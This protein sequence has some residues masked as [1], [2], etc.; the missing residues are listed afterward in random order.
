MWA[1]LSKANEAQ[2]IFRSARFQKKWT[3]Y[4]YPDHV[5]KNFTV[6][7]FFLEDTLYSVSGWCQNGNT[8]SRAITEVKHLELNQF[9][10]G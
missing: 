9:S 3:P 2:T 5:K 8:S 10:D 6:F 7:F 1:V 4:R